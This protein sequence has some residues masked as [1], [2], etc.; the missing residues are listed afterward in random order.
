M[1]TRSF[2]SLGSNKA[3]MLH[4]FSHRLPLKTCIKHGSPKIRNYCSNSK[5]VLTWSSRGWSGRSHSPTS[6]AWATWGQIHNGWHRISYTLGN[7]LWQY[8]LRNV[9]L[10]YRTKMANLMV[11]QNRSIVTEMSKR[12]CVHVHVSREFMKL[13]IN[14]G[15]KKA[16]IAVPD[17]HCTLTCWN[18]WKDNNFFWSEKI[19]IFKNF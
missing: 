6:A 5:T 10:C 16:K 1:I 8:A 2:F 11:M 4:S 19:F 18:W 7:F 15:N 3:W 17:G 9:M 13:Q 12:N 14:A